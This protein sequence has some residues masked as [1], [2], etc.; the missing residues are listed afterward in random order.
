MV[1]DVD[2]N[3]SRAKRNSKPGATKERSA[4]AKAVSKISFGV[5]LLDCANQA[6]ITLFNQVQQ[7][8]PAI[9]VATRYFYYQTQVTFNHAPSTGV[10]AT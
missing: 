7:G 1:M 4:A 2:P 10:I 3:N 6:Q 5:K 8:E 9:N